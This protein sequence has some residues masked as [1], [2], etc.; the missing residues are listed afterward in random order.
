MSE[1]DPSPENLRS[2]QI[3]LG[4]VLEAGEMTTRV[5]AN[6]FLILQGECE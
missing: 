5:D 3:S 1:S 6:A 2:L 4:P